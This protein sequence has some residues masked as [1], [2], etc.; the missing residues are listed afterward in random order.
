M[1]LVKIAETLCNMFNFRGSLICTDLLGTEVDTR[2]P[3]HG[4]SRL[5]TQKPI[6]LLPPLDQ[7]PLLTLPPQ[8]AVETTA[9]YLDAVIYRI[10]R[11]FGDDGEPTPEN[12]AARVS[13]WTG[14]PNLTYLDIE[15]VRATWKRLATLVPYHTG[16]FFIPKTLPRKAREVAYSILQSQQHGIRHSK[17]EMKRFIVNFSAVEE[18]SVL[19]T[20]TGWEHAYRA[21]LWS[22]ARL[23]PWFTPSLNGLGGPIP[24]EQKEYFRDLFVGRIMT[25]DRMLP[26]SWQWFVA[27]IYGEAERWFED[28]ISLHWFMRDH[29]EFLLPYLRRHWE[30][31]RP[32]VEFPLE[33]GKEYAAPGDTEL[34]AATREEVVPDPGLVK[35]DHSESNIGATLGDDWK[36]WSVK[37]QAYAAQA[38]K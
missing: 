36:V 33:V 21:P 25:D 13:K 15:R 22:C 2:P 28:C 11:L 30:L 29:V 18:G 23:P 4:E 10:E 37:W 20:L 35:I 14:T 12:I 5:M 19:V 1:V 7:G 31:H 27:F 26:F 16:G 24:N 9:E 6:L 38:K 8:A 17:M 34:D 32:D 3:V